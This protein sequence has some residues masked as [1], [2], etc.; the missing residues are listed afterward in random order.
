MNGL[1]PEG[2]HDRLPPLADAAATLESRV[3]DVARLHGYERVDPP[4]AEL[5]RSFHRVCETVA[6]A[7]ANRILHRDLKPSNILVDTE[8]RAKV[9]ER[10]RVGEAEVLAAQVRRHAGMALR[11]AFDVHFVD[12]R[13]APRHV[14]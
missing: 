14:R 6:Y 10:R 8:G 3:L 5:L 13:V 2:F 12:D 9:I 7:H 1:L 11:E 4:L